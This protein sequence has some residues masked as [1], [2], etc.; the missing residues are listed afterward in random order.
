MDIQERTELTINDA[1]Q[2]KIDLKLKEAQNK[3]AITNENLENL[4]QE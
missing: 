4:V 2:Q 1:L 3:T